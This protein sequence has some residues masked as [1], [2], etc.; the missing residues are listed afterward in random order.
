MLNPKLYR[1][2]F[3]RYKNKTLEEV[4]PSYLVHLLDKGH[5]RGDLKSY[6]E[7]NY[8]HLKLRAI[9]GK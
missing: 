4:P 3:G 5:A 8:Q 1:L 7:A 6:I 9:N 2:F